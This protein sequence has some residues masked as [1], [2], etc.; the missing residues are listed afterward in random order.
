VPIHWFQ[1]RGVANTIIIILT[2]KNAADIAMRLRLGKPKS[3][4]VGC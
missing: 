3:C 4:H 1:T 2:I